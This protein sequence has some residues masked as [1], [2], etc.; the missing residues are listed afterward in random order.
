M[1]RLKLVDFLLEAPKSGDSVIDAPSPDKVKAKESSWSTGHIVAHDIDHAANQEKLDYE[2]ANIEDVETLP[3][4]WSGGDNLVNKVDYRK[5]QKMLE[6]C[7]CHDKTMDGYHKMREMGHYWHGPGCES[8]PPDMDS[9]R[10]VGD[11]LIR[12]PSL[13][14]FM[15]EP[16][17]D[18]SGAD[19]PVSAAMAVADIADLYSR[20]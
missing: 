18:A 1:S 14:S 5:V 8:S 16:L 20:E 19:C 7:G 2:Y 4:A 17:L 11:I 15:L 9:Y 10:A 6:A 13:I 3:D 12:N